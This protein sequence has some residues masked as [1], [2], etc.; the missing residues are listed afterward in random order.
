MILII[1]ISILLF[2]ITI[3][4]HLLVFHV[5]NRSL[6]KYNQSNLADIIYKAAAIMI[7]HSS[8]IILY[9]AVYY[10]LTQNLLYGHL[11]GDIT[12]EFFEYI[13]YSIVSYTS[14]GLGDVW[15]HGPVRL[16]TG[17]EAIN[18]L[19]LI[20]WSIMYSYPSLVKISSLDIEK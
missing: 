18:G 17:V 5:T 8:Q 4:I 15:P 1:I 13:Y 6:K 2:Y 7:A 11:S 16:L 14:L 12:N 9:A 20:G 10:M 19:F 3:L